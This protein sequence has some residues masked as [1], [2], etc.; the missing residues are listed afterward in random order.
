MRRPNTVRNYSD[1][2][3]TFT[4]AAGSHTLAFVG[5]DTN[6][7]DNTVFIDNVRITLAPSLAVPRLT[8]QLAGRQI[9]I[10][11]PPDHI[12]WELQVQTNAF[13][14]G[15]GTNWVTRFGTPSTNQFIFPIDVA[16]GS[17]FFRLIY[18]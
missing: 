6:G 18:P 9:Q 14:F 12:G 7:G 11:W 2:N 16:N 4:V 13:N 5:T 1:Y 10:L 17:V 3:G 15:L 8:W